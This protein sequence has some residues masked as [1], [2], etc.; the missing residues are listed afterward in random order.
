MFSAAYDARYWGLSD[1][2]EAIFAGNPSFLP[3]A[4]SF[5]YTG[6]PEPTAVDAGIDPMIASAMAADEIPVTVAVD[7]E[8]EAAKGKMDSE[9]NN[10]TF[11]EMI[12]AVLDDAYSKVNAFQAYV[13]SIRPTI[14]VQSTTTGGGGGASIDDG[15][16]GGGHG[17]S[18][19]TLSAHGRF[20]ECGAR[21]IWLYMA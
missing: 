7:V 19:R 14:V 13:E 2:R 20:A 17:N 21:G 10:Q 5:T 11:T 3:Q 18:G 12:D 4:Q 16:G 15:G 9:L 1:A 8:T 6:V